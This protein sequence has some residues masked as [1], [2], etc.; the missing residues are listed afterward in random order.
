MIALVFAISFAQL[1]VKPVTVAIV[2]RIGLCVDNIELAGAAGSS[3]R[4]S[5]L[6]A[7]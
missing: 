7:R 3:W 4:V 1:I 2:I 6:A 5:S